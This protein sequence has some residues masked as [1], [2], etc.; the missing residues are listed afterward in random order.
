MGQK[1]AKLTQKAT[2]TCQLIVKELTSVGDITSRKMFGGYG[3]FESGVM[4]AL[5]NSDGALHLKANDSNIGCFEEA[6]SGRHGK[7]P[8]YEVP[9]KVLKDQT[10]LCEWAKV[11][12]EIAH[13]GKK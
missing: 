2:E 10:L 1:G 9:A 6:D 5:V 7:M 4:F 8:Y 3:I 12:I 11:S 13:S